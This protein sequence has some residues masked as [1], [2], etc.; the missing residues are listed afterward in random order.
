MAFSLIAASAKHPERDIYEAGQILE[1]ILKS[2]EDM[3]KRRIFDLFREIKL[4]QQQHHHQQ[5]E[6]GQAGRQQQQDIDQ[7]SIDALAA[8]DTARGGPE[9]AEAGATNE[10]TGVEVCAC[11]K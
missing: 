11:V 6:E 8:P 5:Q 1:A 3:S 2:R 4:L 9:E 7:G 10:G